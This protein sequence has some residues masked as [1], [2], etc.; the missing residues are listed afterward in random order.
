MILTAEHHEQVLQ[1]SCARTHH[2][3][4]STLTPKSSQPLLLHKLPHQAGCPGLGLL[5]Q[6][7]SGASSPG[8]NWLPQPGLHLP[9]PVLRKAAFGG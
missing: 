8:D 1:L 2:T 7:T 3:H 6:A 9:I 4:T 5:F